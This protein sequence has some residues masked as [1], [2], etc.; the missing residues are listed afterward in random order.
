MEFSPCLMDN[1][2]YNDKWPFSI[3]FCKRLPEANSTDWV[4]DHPKSWGSASRYIFPKGVPTGP[5]ARVDVY[6][7][8]GEN[9]PRNWIDSPK[10]TLGPGGSIFCRKAR[11]LEL[12]KK[13]LLK[14][15][16]S[17]TVLRL[18]MSL[19]TSDE[20]AKFQKRRVSDFP[21]TYHPIINQS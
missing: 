21:Y 20:F 2:N 13:I 18:G 9:P 5:R 14:N 3:A 16:E 10:K 6:L 15:W 12:D 4:Q 17:L 1:S 19:W 11:L 8:T 7:A